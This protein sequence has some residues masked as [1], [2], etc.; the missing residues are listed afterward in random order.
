MFDFIGSRMQKAIAKA[1]NETIKRRGYFR[2]YK[3]Y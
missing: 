2:N 3:R 1:I